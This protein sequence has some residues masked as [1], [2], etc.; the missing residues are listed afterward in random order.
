MANI[1]KPR[2][3]L[4]QLKNDRTTTVKIKPSDLLEIIELGIIIPLSKALNASEFYDTLKKAASDFNSDAALNGN[5]PIDFDDLHT[6]YSEY[7]EA[8]KIF[9]REPAF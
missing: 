4:T 1:I 3:F 8:L 6:K 5:L 9:M 2:D 7:I